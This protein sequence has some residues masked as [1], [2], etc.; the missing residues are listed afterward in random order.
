[1]AGKVLSVASECVPL[2]KTGGLAD[3]VGALPAALAPLGWQMRTL[4]P[5]YRS[6]MPHLGTMRAVMALP[7]LFGGPARVMA[8]QVLGLDMLLLDAPHLYDRAGVP[9]S[10]DKGD[11][12]DNAQR[13]AALSWVG[14]RIARAGVA[15]WKPD[16]LHAHDWQ[17]GFA[18]AY[19]K[20]H[21][22]GGAASVITIHN[23]AFQ[24]WADAG[25]LGALHLP[26]SA[27]HA[28]A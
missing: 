10:N 28:D 11:F 25:L 24:G 16:V 19:M 4:L 21:G 3:V 9:Y 26:Q 6:L 27:F 20:Y 18:P 13:F 8:G 17:A 22:S 1:M 23:I 2:I 5:A 7:D 15:G 12:A 14:A